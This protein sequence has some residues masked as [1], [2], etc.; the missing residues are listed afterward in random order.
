[1][2]RPFTGTREGDIMEEVVKDME[3]ILRKG[4]VRDANNRCN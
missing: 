3:D 1:M 4:W 2:A